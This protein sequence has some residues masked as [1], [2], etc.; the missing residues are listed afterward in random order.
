[1]LQYDGLCVYL[2][3]LVDISIRCIFKTKTISI[4]V[5]IYHTAVWGI[6]TVAPIIHNLHTTCM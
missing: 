3:H 2:P 1:M 5:C 6:I 4:Y